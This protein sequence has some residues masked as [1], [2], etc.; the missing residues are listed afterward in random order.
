MEPAQME[1]LW[2]AC[3]EWVEKNK[4]RAPESIYQVDSVA[5]ALFALGEIVCE[6]VGYHK[7]ED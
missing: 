7:D 2:R 3:Q 6:H 1:S 4:V 5:V